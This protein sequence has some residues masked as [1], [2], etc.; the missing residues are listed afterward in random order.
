MPSS[1]HSCS[2]LPTWYALLCRCSSYATWAHY[3]PSCLSILTP[4][5]GSDLVCGYRSHC[6]SHRCSAHCWALTS[7]SAFS[8]IEHPCLPHLGSIIMEEKPQCPMGTLSYVCQ[9]VATTSDTILIVP[10]IFLDCHLP[11]LLL[12]KLT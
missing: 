8:P 9:E 3:C 12:R 1:P 2:K 6:P 11:P 10:T 4:F 5:L 7:T